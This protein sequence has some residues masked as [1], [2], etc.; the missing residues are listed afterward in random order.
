MLGAEFNDK[1]AFD[2]G[3]VC[4]YLYDVSFDILPFLASDEQDGEKRERESENI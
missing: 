3:N 4:L 1:H 2:L